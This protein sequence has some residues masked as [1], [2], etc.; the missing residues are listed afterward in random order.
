MRA[1]EEEAELK[2]VASSKLMQNAGRGIAEIIHAMGQEN[3]WDEV[4]SLI[5][6]G[7]NGGDALV[8]LAW[9]A[10]TGWRTHAYLV[11]PR[12]NDRLM[13]RY[14]DLGGEVEESWSSQSDGVLQNLLDMSDVLLDGVLGTGIKLPL[15]S[16]IGAVL[17]ETK[18][19]IA[20]LEL[21][22]YVVA[23]D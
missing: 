14:L 7:N 3:G 17:L 10:E 22:P 4:T 15:K 5:G 23:V 21:P 16:E 12:E 18:R 2:G 19:I 8:A 9:L 20:G 13:Q 1:I 6:P 11:K